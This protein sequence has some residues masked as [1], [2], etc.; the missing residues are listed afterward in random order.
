M[1]RLRQLQTK[2]QTLV[3]LLTLLCGLFMMWG[4]A[5][6]T[7]EDSSNQRHLRDELVEI[8]P[9]V[10]SS[11]NNGSVVLASG[12]FSSPQQ[13]EDEFLVPGKYLI[14]KRRVE[15]FQWREE[16]GPSS[17]QA[18]YRLG[19]Y[20]GQIDFFSF[21]NPTGHE[22][23]LL[24]HEPFTKNVDSVMF[25]GFDGV[26]LMRSVRVLVPLELR[27]DILKDPSAEIEDNKIIIRRSSAAEGGVQLG[28]MRVWYEVLPQGDYTVLARQVDERSLI[29]AQPT[30]DMVLRAGLF[31]ANEFFKAHTEESQKVSD[32]LLYIGGFL[33][34]IGLYAILSPFSARM[35]LR[36]KLQLDGSAALLVICA[37]LALVAVSIFFVIGRFG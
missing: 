32:G 4:S 21:K 29:G 17:G 33:F 22:N 5:R 7:V 1:T 12:R 37:V 26:M 8:D 36:P 6:G 31:S 3:A 2:T 20:E 18:E 27:S 35:T 34:F 25:G 15:M 13:L 14:L 30:Q 28:D 16:K 19:W 10:P 23:P 9:L 24:R 11:A